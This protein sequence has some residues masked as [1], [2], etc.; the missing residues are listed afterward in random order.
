M[1]ITAI[2]GCLSIVLVTVLLIRQHFC[3]SAILE[4]HDR[5][6]GIAA[7]EINA[8]DLVYRDSSGCFR[9]CSSNSTPSGQ[10][11]PPAPESL[12]LF[13]PPLRDNTQRQSHDPS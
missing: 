8:G 13:T 5:L 12:A 11:I 1:L 7:E 10:D 3:V 9:K 2:A 4:A 6:R